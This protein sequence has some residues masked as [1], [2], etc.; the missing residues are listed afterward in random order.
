M[1]DSATAVEDK[2]NPTACQL[3][4]KIPKKDMP[5]ILLFVDVGLNWQKLEFLATYLKRWKHEACFVAA[6]VPAYLYHHFGNVGLCFFL[7][8]VCN[9]VKSQGWNKKEDHL[10]TAGE[11]ALDKVVKPYAEDLRMNMM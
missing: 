5:D 4:M 3:L 10:V 7:P 11:E 8:Y 6:N 2:K 9:T 1:D